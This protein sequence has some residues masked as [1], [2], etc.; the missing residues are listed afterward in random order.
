MLALPEDRRFRATDLDYDYLSE[1]T[2]ILRRKVV[3]PTTD[4]RAFP[5]L[6]EEGTGIVL[7]SWYRDAAHALHEIDFRGNR[8]R[9]LLDANIFIGTEK[10]GILT[11]LEQWFGEP[12]HNPIYPLGGN[13]LPG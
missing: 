12:Y 6:S 11:Q 13:G 4:E 7:Q 8:Y 1:R 3:N 2:A 10:A 5:R 9:D